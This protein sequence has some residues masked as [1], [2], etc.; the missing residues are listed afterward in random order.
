M[1]GRIK[2]PV[3]R[4]RR[5]SQGNWGCDNQPTGS[6]GQR[7]RIDGA[8]LGLSYVPGPHIIWRAAWA[9]SFYEDPI[10]MGLRTLDEEG[11]LTIECQLHF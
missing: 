7:G 4:T 1:A 10:S 9:H 11:L 6:G 5:F 3:A 8:R 2:P